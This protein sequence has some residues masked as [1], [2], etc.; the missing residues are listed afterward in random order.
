MPAHSTVA[1]IASSN[2]KRPVLFRRTMTN[3]PPAPTMH[4]WRKFR[5]G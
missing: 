4:V 1:V 5:L 2:L 3:G